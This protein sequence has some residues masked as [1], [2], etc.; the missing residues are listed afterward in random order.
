MRNKLITIMV[1]ALFILPYLPIQSAEAANPWDQ[2]KIWKKKAPVKDLRNYLAYEH[3]EHEKLILYLLVLGIYTWNIT[4]DLL[5]NLETYVIMNPKPLEP[6]VLNVMNFFIFNLQVAYIL[7]IAGTALYII[8]AAGTPKKRAK[9]KSMMGRLVVGMLLVSVSP[10]IINLFLNFTS[11]MAAT[12]LNQADST[13]AATVYTDLIWKTYWPSVAIILAPMVGHSLEQWSHHAVVDKIRNDYVASSADARRD[14]VVEQLLGAG[15]PEAIIADTADTIMKDQEQIIRKDGN[16]KADAKSWGQKQ[17]F[18][19]WG[20]LESKFKLMKI[21]PKPEQTFAFL[22]SEIALIIGLYGF[23]ALRYLMLM[24]WTVLFPLSLFLSSFEMTRGIGRNMIEQT[25]F[26]SILQV[27]YAVTIDVIAVGF[28][29]LPS[30][31]GYFGLGLQFPGISLFFIS[32]FS[33]AAAFLLLLTP[34]LVLMLSQRL[35]QMDVG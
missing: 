24:I 26:W 27:F 31:F 2:F 13:V 15:N 11:G 16:F 28:T 22:M 33:V 3:Y 29:I 10:Y 35:S 20:T 32:F 25:I 30:G 17:G 8:F 9:A 5:T 1:I 19:S 7:A 23:L 18:L 12:I 21:A 6:S 34:I 14:N 4:T